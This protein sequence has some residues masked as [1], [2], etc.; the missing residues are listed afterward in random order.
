MKNL[1]SGLIATLMLLGVTVMAQE[2]QRNGG[3]QQSPE[4]QTKNRIER[5]D[6]E[7]KL[8]Q[9]QKDSIYVY[10]LDL[11]K[12]QQEIFKNTT[13]RKAA[14]ENIKTVRQSTDA[15]IKSF[16]NPEQSKSYD[17]MQEEMQQRRQQRQKK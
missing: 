17:R 12:K 14:F 2:K 16:L 13:D 8:S 9:N 3:Q 7:L 15:K 1:K 10:A 6:K 4:D 11:S 5:L